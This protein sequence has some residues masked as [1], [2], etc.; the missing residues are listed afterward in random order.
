MQESVDLEYKY[1][2]EEGKEWWWGWRGVKINIR[3][4]QF[5]V[6]WRGASLPPW[7][8]P[9]PGLLSRPSLFGDRYLLHF[10]MEIISNSLT[11]EDLK[12]QL[13]RSED[14]PAPSIR[15]VPNIFLRIE[16]RG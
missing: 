3:A 13:G 12:P 1:M 9:Q 7:T 2:Y 10:R 4:P 14:V 15:V 16:R 11:D 6:Q 8:L 5:F